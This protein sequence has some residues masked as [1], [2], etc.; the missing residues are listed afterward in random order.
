VTDG[1][2][3][4][5]LPTSAMVWGMRFS[6]DGRQIFAATF[7]GGIDVLESTTDAK[8]RTTPGHQRLIPGLALSSD[9]SMLATGSEDGTIKVWHAASMNRLLTFDSIAGEIITTAFDPSGRWLAATTGGGMVMV[10][11][12]HSSRRFIEANRKYQAGL[13]AAKP[14]P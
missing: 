10:I 14:T 11:D 4:G 7:S 8:P 13:R 6:P 2:A 5:V 9:G 3:V 12:L 1:Q